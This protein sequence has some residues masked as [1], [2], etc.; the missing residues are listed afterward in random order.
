MSLLTLSNRWLKTYIRI[1]LEATN[2]VVTLAGNPAAGRR[3]ALDIERLTKEAGYAK[4]YHRFINLLGG[5]SLNT[6]LLPQWLSAWGYAFDSAA[7]LSN[8]PELD[9][10]RR[11]YY[12]RGFQTLIDIEKPEAILWTLLTT[13]E[14][15]IHTLANTDDTESHQS[16]WNSVLHRLQLSTKSTASRFEELQQYLDDIEHIIGLWA[17]QVGV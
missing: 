4:I 6:T 15:A 5:E 8:E 1:V 9:P 17:E 12:L 10:C 3:L 14:R 7:A 16:E 11:M 13:W 2:A